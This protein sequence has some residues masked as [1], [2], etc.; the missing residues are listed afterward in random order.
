MLFSNESIAVPLTAMNTREL[1][2]TTALLEGTTGI[3]LILFPSSVA[4]LLLGAALDAP[5]ALVV[6]GVAGAALLALALA[7]WLLRNETARGTARAFLAA[8]GLYNIAVAIILVQAALAGLSG[9]GLWP[10]V[11]LHTAFALWCGTCFRR[12][13]A[14]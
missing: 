1:F 8:L 13:S 5:A 7:C 4:Q 3:A 2:V 14:A 11:V 9:P 6:A 10:T 12:T